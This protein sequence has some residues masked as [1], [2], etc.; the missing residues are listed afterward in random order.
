MRDKEIKRLNLLELMDYINNTKNVFN[1]QTFPEIIEMISANLF[2]GLAPSSQT[3]HQQYD[4]EEEEP[5][6]LQYAGLWTQRD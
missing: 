4:P 6:R 1:E 5:A 2:R 3:A